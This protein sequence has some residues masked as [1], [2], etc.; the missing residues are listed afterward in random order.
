[1]SSSRAMSSPLANPTAWDNV[2]DG[3]LG[4]L[5]PFFT[6]YAKDA[7]ELA[8]FPQGAT[9]LDL[10]CGPGTLALLAARQGA[11][12]TAVD[13]SPAMI[14]LLVHQVEEEKLTNLT[15]KVGDG[16]R[17]AL[18]S[19]SFDVAFSLF[20]VIFF[21]HRSQGLSELYRTLKPGGKLVL[22]SWVPVERVP[23]LK[24]LW[25]IVGDLEPDLPYGNNKA[26]MGEPTDI[27]MEMAMAGFVETQVKTVS[28]SLVYPTTRDFWQSMLRSS[29]PLAL[30]QQ[31]LPEQEWQAFQEKAYKRLVAEMG[32]GE[33]RAKW[34][35]HI[36]MGKKP[37]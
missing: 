27:H 34:P 1:M 7:L 21:T 14:E 22:S 2:A 20:G 36:G 3:Y 19:E 28:H 33:V 12:V 24:T 37:A 5:L 29:P 23:T 30:I 26:P 18:S 32:D 35:A 6:H 16:Q 31:R 17:L 15:A 13:F 8:A 9:V 10:A 25:S 4:D 11:Q